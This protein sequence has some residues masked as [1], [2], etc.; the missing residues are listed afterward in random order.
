M[1]EI[2][3]KRLCKATPHI[4]LLKLKPELS[5]QETTEVSGNEDVVNDQGDAEANVNDNTSCEHNSDISRFKC[6][7]CFKRMI[8][9]R[10][11]SDNDEI[12]L[13]E[14]N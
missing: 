7:F 10:R 3:K 11:E 12:P 2:I 8:V 9:C 1:Q 13:V 14:M 5:D 4:P 6:C